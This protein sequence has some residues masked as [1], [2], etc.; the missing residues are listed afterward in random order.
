MECLMNDQQLKELLQSKKA[1]NSSLLTTPND[2]WE[3]ICQ[4]IE[5]EDKSIHKNSISKSKIITLSIF[6]LVFIGAG[7]KMINQNKV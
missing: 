6:V 2:E 7:A 3:K 1:E 4:S 5:M